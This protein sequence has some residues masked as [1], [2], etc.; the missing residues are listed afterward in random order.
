MATQTQ[1]IQQ[2]DADDQG[3]TSSDEEEEDEW[4]LGFVEER[5]EEDGPCVMHEDPCWKS[6]D[7]GKAGGKPSWLDPR[8]PDRAAL[9]CEACKQTMSFML[10]VYAPSEL[11]QGFHRAMYVFC[12]KN[13]FCLAKGVGVKALRC[14][15]P[16][17]NDFYAEV[18]PEDDDEPV[19]MPVKPDQCGVCGLAAPLKCSAC[20]A[21]W[22]CCKEHQADHWKAAHKAC[23]GAGP[24]AAVAADAAAAAEA[25]APPHGPGH[26]AMNPSL[27]PEFDISIEEEPEQEEIEAADDTAQI[28]AKLGMNDGHVEKNKSFKPADMLEE[29]ELAKTGKKR[30]TDRLTTKFSLRSMRAPTQCI[31]YANEWVDRPHE[32]LWAHSAGRPLGAEEGTLFDFDAAEGA[33]AAAGSIDIPACRCGAPR[34]LEF[35]VMPQILHYMGVEAATQ[36]SSDIGH[37]TLDFGTL[38]V[39]CCTACC[40]PEDPAQP[41]QEEFVWIQPPEEIKDLDAEPIRD[42]T[43][44]TG[45]VYEPDHDLD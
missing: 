6:W 8:A 9:T 15:L 24:A 34:H 45:E 26:P 5:D 32:P 3:F 37:S 31:R 27:F 7:G 38:A 12:C 44:D 13:G 10:Q 22:Y 42:S 43:V 2:A 40:E 29:D 16:R 18:C 30:V 14:I 39:Y 1:D 20:K 36:I 28:M 41:Y 11:D 35:Q 21:A 33:E 19:E 4:Q 23:C 17:K 25:A